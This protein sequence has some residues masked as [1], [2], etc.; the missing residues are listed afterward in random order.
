MGSQRE[1]DP[2]EHL[3]SSRLSNQCKFEGDGRAMSRSSSGEPSLELPTLP[4][5]LSDA[6]GGVLE[7]EER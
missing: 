5:S 7:R 3:A 2:I 4:S 1:S 6:R